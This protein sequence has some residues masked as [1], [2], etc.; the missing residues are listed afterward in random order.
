MDITRFASLTR[1]LSNPHSRRAAFSSLLAGTLGP[2]ELDLLVSFAEFPWFR[3]AAIGALTNVQLPSPHHLYWPDLDIDL[4]VVRKQ[5]PR[6]DG[7]VDELT[8]GQQ[9]SPVLEYVESIGGA[10]LIAL[11]LRAFVVEAFKIP[12][13]SMIPTLAIGDHIFALG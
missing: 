6:L 11:A 5:L 2:R 1:A 12:S 9:R 13:S 8:A 10:I 4:A 3:E 7:L